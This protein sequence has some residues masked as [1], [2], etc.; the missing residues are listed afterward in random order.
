MSQTMRVIKRTEVEVPGLGRKIREARLGDSR[1]L[2]DICDQVG[3][4]SM[5]WYRIEAESQS[6]PLETLRRIESVFSID[7][8]VSIDD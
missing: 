5:N 8:G 6:L 3:M 4:S 2:K 1:S 7:L